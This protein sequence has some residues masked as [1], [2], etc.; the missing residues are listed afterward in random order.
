[1]KKVIRPIKSV[2]QGNAF[3]LTD[4]DVADKPNFF[5]LDRFLIAKSIISQ[6]VLPNCENFC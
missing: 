4:R 6:R 3:L 5:A 2:I 1:M